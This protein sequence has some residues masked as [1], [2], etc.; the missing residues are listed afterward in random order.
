MFLVCLLPLY[1]LVSLCLSFALS[2]CVLPVFLS[3]SP[4]SLLTPRLLPFSARLP[5]PLLR[6]ISQPRR[7]TDGLVILEASGWRIVLL[8]VCISLFYCLFHVF[9][10]FCK[11]DWNPNLL[12]FIF[13]IMEVL[14]FQ[15]DSSLSAPGK[16]YR[17]V[18]RLS[19]LD[20]CVDDWVTFWHR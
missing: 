15:L 10:R 4:P 5:S 12:L 20:W 3:C 2:L 14:W 18:S 17:C 7:K 19:Y 6:A 11:T 13:C 1:L 8:C 16:K 9:F